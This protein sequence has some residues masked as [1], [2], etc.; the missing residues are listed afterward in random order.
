M[1]IIQSIKNMQRITRDLKQ[2]AKSVGFVPTMGA[3]HTGHLS[4][5]KQAAKENDFL[6]VSIFVNPT[7]FG[8]REDFRSYPRSLKA[9]ALLCKK[10]GVNII[11]YPDTRQIYP[12][13]Y[14]AYVV[15]E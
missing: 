11:F 13:G 15:V 9:D 12:K 2:D 8:P 10:E 14:K 4:L 3:L 5:I 6:I 7:Q 1:K